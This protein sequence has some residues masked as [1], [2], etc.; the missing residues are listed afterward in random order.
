MKFAS[1]KLTW[2]NILLYFMG[3][4]LIAFGVILMTKSSIGNSSWDTLHWSLHQ[5]FGF[6]MGWATIV[7]AVTLTAL[8]IFFNKDLSY[9]FMLL[10]IFLVGYEI[11]LFFKVFAELE[12]GSFIEQIGL[13]IAG[14]LLLPLGGSLLIISTLPAGIFD[15]FNLT[16]MRLFNSTNLPRIRGIMEILAVLTALVIGYFAGI[17][18]GKVNIGTLIFSLSVGYILRTYL[19]IFERIG[20][21]ENQQID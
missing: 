13:Y 21:Y 19:K 18:F 9:L 12:P 17:G 1:V 20:Y 8:V 11:D 10:P 2:L 7:V 16:L 6:S 4:L 3:C 14:G 5:L 15:E